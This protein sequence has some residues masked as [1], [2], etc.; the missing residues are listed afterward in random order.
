MMIRLLKLMAVV[1]ALALATQGC[2]VFVGDEDD[3]HH[4]REHWG[5]HGHG[6]RQHSSLEQIPQYAKQVD[7]N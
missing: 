2:A 5:P 6:G 3:F 4:H 1:F 7:G